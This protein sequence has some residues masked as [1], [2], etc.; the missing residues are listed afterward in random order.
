MILGFF[1]IEAS[2]EH[3]LL[4]LDFKAKT[5]PVSPTFKEKSDSIGAVTVRLNPNVSNLCLGHTRRKCTTVTWGLTIT[6]DY[7]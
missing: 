2:L 6:L 5:V 1:A 3:D 4:S 7:P